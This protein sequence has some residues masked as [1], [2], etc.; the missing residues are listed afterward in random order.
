MRGEFSKNERGNRRF[1]CIRMAI[2]CSPNHTNQ[3]PYYIPG[4]RSVRGPARRVGQYSK[5]LMILTGDWG[6]PICKRTVGYPSS[7]E[8]RR[9]DTGVRCC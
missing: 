3:L 1:I 9:R 4:S 6:G 7:Q 8:P 2:V 5:H